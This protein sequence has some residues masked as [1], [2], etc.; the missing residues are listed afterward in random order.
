MDSLVTKK[1]LRIV[2]VCFLLTCIS[3]Y[4]I[5]SP[6]LTGQNIAAFIKRYNHQMLAAFFIVCVVRGFTLVPSTPFLLTGII[7]FSATPILLLIVFMAS[8]FVVA[9][10]LFYASDYLGFAR[11]FEKRYPHKTE[12]VRRK[13]NGRYGFWF[14]LIWSFTP[15]TPTDLVCYV[16]GSLRMRF[17]KFILPL[18]LGEAIICAIYI[19]NGA[20]L[21]YK[22]Q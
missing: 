11:Y 8:I 5:Y 20:A 12:Q 9:T 22:Q 1:F 4:V 21:L 3:L 10:L 15:F 16:A 17:M 7:L 2:W 14:I 6:Y 18:I 13:L 19:F